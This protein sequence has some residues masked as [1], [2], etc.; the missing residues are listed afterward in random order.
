MSSAPGH[1]RS[2]RHRSTGSE[3]M[4]RIDV[5]IENP[6]IGRMKNSECKML[7]SLT[8]VENPLESIRGAAGLLL[9]FWYEMNRVWPPLR[10]RVPLSKS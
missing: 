6:P 3:Q 1:C 10:D 2:G 5:E 9:A 7:W 4:E 8:R